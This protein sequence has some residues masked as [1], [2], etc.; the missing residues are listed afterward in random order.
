MQEWREDIDNPKDDHRHLSHL[1]GLYP[2]HQISPFTSPTARGRGPKVSLLA[3]GDI[4]TGWS[5]AWKICFWARLLDGDHAYRLLRD[6]ITPIHSTAMNYVNGGGV[7]A[8][9]L[10]AHP[11]FQ[12]DGN[13][14]ATAAIAEML[15]QSQTGELVL[16]PALPSAWP[17]GSV[18][19]LRAR[20]GFEVG[21]IWEN[22]KLHSATI[23]SLV[24]APCR[25]RV[26]GK[27]SEVS[28]ARGQTITLH[29]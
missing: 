2:G 23:H 26:G 16:L 25:V 1:V 4:G 14:G 18:S 8:N 24:G 22:G 19:G 29:Y 13:F 12:I 6:L 27:V 9:L 7:Y 11:P 17:T 28:L 21:L 3:R 15:L 5:K 20:G 10:D